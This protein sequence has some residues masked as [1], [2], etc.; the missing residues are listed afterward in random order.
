MKS[1]PKIAELRSLFVQLRRHI[2]DYMIDEEDDKPSI[3]VTIGW[4]DET[5]HWSYQTGDNSYTGGAYGYPHWASVH[6]YRTGNLT[7]LAKDVRQGL[8]SCIDWR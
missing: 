4:N 5:G 2:E 8:L 3:Y 6:V 7:N 1:L